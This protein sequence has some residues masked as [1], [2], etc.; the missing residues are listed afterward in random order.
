MVCFV[1]KSVPEHLVQVVDIKSL[2][3]G[4]KT[5]VSADD[6]LSETFLA[7][8]R[9]CQGSALSPLLFI[10]VMDIL[11]EDVRDGSLWELLHADDLQ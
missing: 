2:Y 11:M 4:C 9:T 1:N 10:I 6:N 3:N 5:T 7:Q 8:V